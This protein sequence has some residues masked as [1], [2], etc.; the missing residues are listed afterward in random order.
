MSVQTQI[1]RISGAVSAA[2]AALTE[3]GV[4][5]PAGTK[6]DD[7]ATLIAAIEAGGGGDLVYATGTFTPAKNVTYM[8]VTHGLGVVPKIVLFVSENTGLINS[9]YLYGLHLDG[10]SGALWVTSAQKDI[11]GRLDQSW[12]ITSTDTGMVYQYSSLVANNATEQTIQ[13]GNTGREAFAAGSI[14]FLASRRYRWLV[15][16]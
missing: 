3:K 1:D 11:Y 4:T 9:S 13:I 8:D 5:V 14:G 2:L 10:K 7:M 6:V 12:D 16:G 15:I